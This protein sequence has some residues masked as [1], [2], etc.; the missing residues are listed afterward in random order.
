MNRMVPVPDSCEH[1]NRSLGSLKVMEFLDRFRLDDDH[2]WGVSKNLKGGGRDLFP[3]INLDSENLS[4][5]CQP[6][7]YE[8][9]C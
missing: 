9:E 6:P 5:A 1:C 8:A 2:H 7:E 3:G 4:R